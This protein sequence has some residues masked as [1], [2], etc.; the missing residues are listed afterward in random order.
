LVLVVVE[1]NPVVVELVVA[2]AVL[3]ESFV[4]RICCLMQVL[5]L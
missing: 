3:V 1:E 2:A 4:C 5:I